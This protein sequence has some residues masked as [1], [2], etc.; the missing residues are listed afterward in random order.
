VLFCVDLSK[1]EKLKSA[2]ATFE[3]ISAFPWF[4]NTAFFIVFTRNDIF[5]GISPH[6]FFCFVY[7]S[8]NFL[9]IEKM[10][11]F[12]WHESFATYN[13][14]TDSEKARKYIESEFISRYFFPFV[15]CFLFF[16]L[17]LFV[18]V[19]NIKI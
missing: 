5:S 11:D 15:F 16:C 1:L 14:G 18:F 19:F 10:A 4:T 13:C 2:I 17:C 9:S 6:L 12:S 8:V 7:F 3:K